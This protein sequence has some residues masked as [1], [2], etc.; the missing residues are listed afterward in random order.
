MAAYYQCLLTGSLSPLRISNI[1]KPFM[2]ETEHERVREKIA[3]KA[4]EGLETEAGG[5]PKQTR[6]GR[7]GGR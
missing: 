3:E 6:K 4:K 5:G 7:K 1:C 2:P